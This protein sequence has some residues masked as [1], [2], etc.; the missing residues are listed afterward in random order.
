MPAA[1]SRIPVHSPVPSKPQTAMWVLRTTK[2][3]RSGLSTRQHTGLVSTTAMVGS[4]PLNGPVKLL[5]Y[6][7]SPDL[8]SRPTSQAATQIQVD[9][10]WHS[11]HFLADV[12]WTHTWT[13]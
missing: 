6:G 2:A 12:T 11:R 10:D 7:T 3:A 8:P 13:T 9:G 4:M 5:A 1:Q